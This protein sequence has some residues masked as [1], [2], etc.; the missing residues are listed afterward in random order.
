M[1]NTKACSFA[2]PFK[3]DAETH[4]ALDLTSMLFKR[5]G[6]HVHAGLVSEDF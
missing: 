4:A 5:G 6:M 2:M 3:A 1:S